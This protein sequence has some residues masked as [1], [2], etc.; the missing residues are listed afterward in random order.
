MISTHPFSDGGVAH[1]TEN[2]IQ[3]LTNHKVEVVL[4][5]NSPNGKKTARRELSK[6]KN[7]SICVCWRRG[8]FYP[9]QI[10]KRV[11]EK[12][13]DLVHIQHEFFLY[14]GTISAA[15]FPFLLL[16][17]KF[18][19]IP[20]VVTLH[21]VI[22]LSE[23]N[24]Q[25]LKENKLNGRSTLL[26]FGSIFSIKV[27]LLLA[28]AVIVHEKCFVEVLKNDYKCAKKIVMIPHGIEVANN[29]MTPD[30]AKRKL[31]LL[32]RTIVFFFGYISPYKG[33]DTLVEG[34]GKVAKEHKDWTLIIGG[35]EHPRLQK[36]AAYN[37]YVRELKK[38]AFNL[39]PHQMIFTG[40]VR[41]E[42]LPVYFS[43]AD[44]VV[45]PHN[46]AMS[47]SGPL[48]YAIGYQKPVLLSA[49]APFKEMIDVEEALFKKSSPKS[50]SRKLEFIIQNSEIR[51]KVLLYV[52]KLMLTLSWDNA[53][54]K[55][56]KLYEKQLCG[57]N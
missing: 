55:T 18:L 12:N 50:L 15:L 43:A 47:A 51:Q 2:L 34:F 45:F 14:G 27:I 30:E 44:L 28:N 52:Q 10:F 13:V 25:F 22:P 23:V 17:L 40:F 6:S 31:G 5:S 7:L 42:D 37:N 35:G 39:A 21:G 9:F 24:K 49:I 32:N 8:L 11:V 20:L 3:A 57:I 41:D 53:G 16:F 46:V 26:K 1:Y 56:I 33:L 38:K 4:F 29:K 48:A 36:D 19:Q 54:K